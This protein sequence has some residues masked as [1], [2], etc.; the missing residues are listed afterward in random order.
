[1]RTPKIF[2]YHNQAVVLAHVARWWVAPEAIDG[3]S[4]I[5]ELASGH[6]AIFTPK[7]AIPKRTA[8]Q[9]EAELAACFDAQ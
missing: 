6:T 9:L 1:M 4:L 2:R 8:E 3:P 5:V 7:N